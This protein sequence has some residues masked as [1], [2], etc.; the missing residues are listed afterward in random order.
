MPKPKLNQQKYSLSNSTLIVVF[1]FL[2]FFSC[3][4]VYSDKPK[5][6]SILPA[7]PHPQ[8]GVFS[9]PSIETLFASDQEMVLITAWGKAKESG[10]HTLKWEVINSAGDIV[11]SH[12]RNNYTIRDHYYTNHNIPMDSAIKEKLIPGELS[13]NFY[14]DDV[15]SATQ[16]TNYSSKDILKKSGRKVVILPFRETD[17]YPDEWDEDTKNYFQNTYASAVYGEIKRIYPKT[18]PHYETKQKIGNYFKPD[19][20]KDEECIQFLKN[21][22]SDSIF[23]KGES[24]TQHFGIGTTRL[25]LTFFDPVSGQVKIF[26]GATP[27]LGSYPLIPVSYIAD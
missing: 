16:K 3:G 14:L 21:H 13:V 27:Y 5:A 20:F 19:C 2:S 12:T 22:Y 8:T 11:Y 15:L 17:Y 18:V 25:I 6:F 26:S 10:N 24:I 7:L 9:Y 4:C 1:L 23:I